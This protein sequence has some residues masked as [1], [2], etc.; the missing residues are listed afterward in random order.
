MTRRDIHDT[1]GL[2]AQPKGRQMALALA[3]EISTWPDNDPQ[4]IG[5][6]CGACQAVTFPRQARCPQCSGGNMSDVL[7]PRRGTVVA[8]TTQGFPPGPPYA[9]PTGAD[10][11]PFGV[12]LV[13]LGDV[14]RVEGRLTESDPARLAF[15]M[16]VE[17]TMMPLATNENGDEIITFAF[18]PVVTEAQS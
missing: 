10:F 8:W 6:S 13:Q 14:V 1:A 12:G 11:T 5:S 4:L 7:L 9:G 18:R 17:L 2:P 3:P 15:G 16:E